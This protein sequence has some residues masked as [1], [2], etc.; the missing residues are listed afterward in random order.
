MELLWDFLQ[1]LGNFALLWLPIVFMA[2]IV[3]LVWRTLAL[4]PRVKP[5]VVEPTS[6]GSV[7]WAD[8]AGVEEAAAE[9]Q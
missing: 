5:N 1:T 4:M 6:R 8:I 3:Y 7:G 9:L 2:M